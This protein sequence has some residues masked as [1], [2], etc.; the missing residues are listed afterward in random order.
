MTVRVRLF[1]VIKE[2]AGT[3][4]TTVESGTLDEVLATL[5]AR[6]GDEFA[7]RL[8]V[9]TVLVDGDAVRGDATVTVPAGAELALLPPV[10]GGA[11]RRQPYT[12]AS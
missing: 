12:A 6:Y 11:A 5:C 3:A 10:S 2:A 4:E 7:R 1:A 9:C 8:R